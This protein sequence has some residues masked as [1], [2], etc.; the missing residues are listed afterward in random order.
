MEAARTLQLTHQTVEVGDSW[1]RID[2]L[3]LEDRTLVELVRSRL[4]QDVT[5]ED[6]VRDAAEIGARVLDREA[7]QAEVDF[8]RREFERASADV[9]RAFAERAD[10]VARG[11]ES[12]LEQFL[13]DEGGVM[14]KA[15]DAHSQELA[16]A[17]A[18]NF[19]GD[20]STAVQ[21][22][23]RELVERKLQESRQELLRQFSA[24]DGHNPLA[25]FKQAVLRKIDESTE[26]DRGV[27]E[28][29]AKLETQLAR[30]GD[31]ERARDELEA[32]RERSSVKGHGF[33]AQAFELV[34]RLAGER[35]DAAQHVGHERSESGGKRGD[36]VIELEAASSA[37]KGR[38][39]I[40]AKDEKLSRPDAWRVL[41][42]SMAERDAAFAILLIASESKLPAR[43][44]ALHEYEGNKM[45]VELDKETLD[46]RPLE[47]AYRYARCRCL[48]AR[49][50]GMQLDAPGV[51]N[52]VD[53]ALAALRDAQK[54]RGSLTS[55]RNSVDG[56]HGA[57]DNMVDRVRSS[58]ER[59]E[60]LVAAG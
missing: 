28:R 18:R 41:N 1:I 57:L 12:Q 9:E 46:P 53:E 31:A 23:V 49:E 19:G 21:H 60:E 40:E 37:A 11:L 55:A 3:V 59:V 27:A 36:I 20:R 15:L 4:E 30:L 44:E 16:E 39:V 54:I 52:A 45:I 43:T 48:M 58:L 8:V 13:G 14:G 42:E 26:V 22:Q 10:K 7:T 34:E 47:L 51:R 32:E 29:M 25:D 50:Q 38:I 17:L 35:G 6:T 33:E 5:A 24:S 2:G 56:A